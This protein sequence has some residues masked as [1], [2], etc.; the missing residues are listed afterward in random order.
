MLVCL[1]IAGA[2]MPASIIG[3]F[4]VRTSPGRELGAALRCRTYVATDLTTLRPWGW[5]SSFWVRSSRS[6]SP[7]YSRWPSTAGWSPDWSS[8]ASP[9]TT[10]GIST[11]PSGIWPSRH[12]P[13]CNWPRDRG[14]LCLWQPG[15]P[16]RRQFRH[17][18]HRARR[19]RHAGHHGHTI[20]VDA[21]GP[22]ADNAGGI[23]QMAFARGASRYRRGADVDTVAVLRPEA[24]S[25]SRSPGIPSNWPRTS[26]I[27]RSQRVQPP[28]S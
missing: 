18:R 2:G 8:G 25:P 10:P 12:E 17:L 14:C 16:G 20:S 3:A 22:I 6:S 21:Y 1:A 13:R 4:F 24:R 11:A 19:S 9:S 27:M 5:H 23:G 28:R 7:S 15:D 26:T